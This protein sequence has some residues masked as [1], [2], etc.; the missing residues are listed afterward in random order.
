MT[1]EARS[2]LA[3]FQSQGSRAGDFIHF[4]DFGDAIV[5]KDGFIRDEAVRLG[6]A[7]L[8]DK[9]YLVELNEGLELTASGERI[10]RFDTV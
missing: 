3:V 5:W 10:A 4:T 7:W 1:P 2:I 9:E 8:L 6:L